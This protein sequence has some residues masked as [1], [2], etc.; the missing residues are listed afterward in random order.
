M[1]AAVR[2]TIVRGSFVRKWLGNCRHARQYLKAAPWLRK[3][4]LEF[5]FTIPREW[6]GGAYFEL[7]DFPGVGSVNIYRL[8]LQ[9]FAPPHE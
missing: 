1:V 3:D 2:D 4:A 9:E 6:L 8:R 5:R 7:D